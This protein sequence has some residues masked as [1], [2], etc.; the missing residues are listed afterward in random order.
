[1]HKVFLSNGVYFECASDQTILDAAKNN[2][3]AI[4]YSCKNG[5][6]GACVSGVLKGVSTTIVAE[7]FLQTSV[8]ADSVILTCC[9]APLSDIWL[10][11][12]DLGAIGLLRS[13]TL[14]CR[15]DSLEHLVGNI[16]RLHLRLPPNS[17]FRYVPGQYIDLIKGD[18]RRS[19]SIANAP[20]EDGVLELHLKRVEDGSMSDYVFNEAKINDL[21]RFEG[22]MGTFSYRQDQ[23][24]NIVLM[25]T[26]TG[27]APIKALLESFKGCKPDKKIYVVWGDRYKQDLYLEL[28]SEGIDYQ[29]VPVLSRQD[30]KGYF[31]GYVQDAVVDLEL[32]L[33]E[34]TVY[35]CGS[36]D[37]IDS[38][39]KLFFQRGLHRKN[40][41]SDAFVSSN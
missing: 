38:A 31:F 9:R 28:G 30:T 22:P 21:L 15:I 7:K 11:I 4:E 29:F 5:R 39:S 6:C 35:A 33:E 26:G 24:R 8:S 34:T 32:N 37:M 23:S 16:C 13:L 40:F 14:P 2:D 41:H 36:A 17:N 18:I 19:Y 1:M 27:I 3:L 10:D 20:R 25:A 12:E